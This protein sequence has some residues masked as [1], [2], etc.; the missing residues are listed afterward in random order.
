MF[1]PERICVKILHHQ[2]VC[3]IVFVTI[4]LARVRELNKQNWK[5]LQQKNRSLAAA[6]RNTLPKQ[7]SGTVNGLVIQQPLATPL[8]SSQPLITPRCSSQSLITPQC[9]S[10]PLITPQC[11][12][13]PFITPQCSSQPLIIPQCSSQPLS[14]P[15]CPSQ[16]LNIQCIPFTPNFRQPVSLTPAYNMSS[17][18][19]S[20]TARVKVLSEN[21][22][23]INSSERLQCSSDQSLLA[24]QSKSPKRKR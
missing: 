17:R 8:C 13:Q 5:A 16:P 21:V 4:F 7:T 9:P 15:Q 19:P 6:N 14:T 12:S 2:A 11:S 22:Q 3:I 10:Q 23:E 18:A 20:K 1:Q 24:E